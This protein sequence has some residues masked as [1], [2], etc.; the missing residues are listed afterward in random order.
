[1]GGGLGWRVEPHLLTENQS[2]SNR[3]TV[4]QENH[5]YGAPNKNNSKA[6]TEYLSHILVQILAC[7]YLG[8]YCKCVVYHSQSSHFSCSP[9]I[10]D[11]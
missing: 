3:I 5:G 8:L 7:F 6:L 1:M 11:T 2:R 4:S 9:C 10:S